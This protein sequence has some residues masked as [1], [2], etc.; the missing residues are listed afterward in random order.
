MKILYLVHQFYPEYYTGT[1]KFVLNLSSM[2]QKLGNQVK[3]ITYSFRENI[4][5][6]NRIGNI[7]YKDFYYKGIPVKAIKHV[8]VPWDIHFSFKDNEMKEFALK[9]IEDEKPDIVHVGHSMRIGEFIW[10]LI[11]L[12]IPYIITL[13]DFFFICYK[14][15]LLKKSGDLCIGPQGG[16][17]YKYCGE[18]TEQ[19]IKNRLY[20]AHKI[21][22]NAEIVASPSNFV[23]KVIENEFKDIN[24]KVIKHGMSYNNIR[25]N[26]RI[27]KKND[28]LTFCYAG[29]L[30][31][32]KGV[33][34]I[35]DAFT[36]IKNDNISL[37]I[38][39]S[40][41]DKDYIYR[42]EN[43]SKS[44]SRIEFCGVYNEE[45]IGEIYSDADV[46]IVPSLWFENYP[47]VLH[48]A[49]ACNVPVI[50]SNVGGMKEKVKDGYNGFTF[51]I[52]NSDD[53]KMKMQTII[54]N[55]LILNELKSKMKTFMIPTVEQEAYAY[56][57]IYKSII[58]KKM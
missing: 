27:Y 32:H 41:I 10:A 44:D 12:K 17:C 58:Y 13:T 1:E 38:Y 20:D 43:A 54:D 34:I 22:A 19:I 25:K 45:Q 53:L 8:Q 3:I 39:G 6:D 51:E 37:K 26:K 11:K 56:E 4:F 52:G 21:L 23:A 31:P 35:I 28:K 42:L 30:T 49:L 7:L 55:S 16:I 50:A 46:S 9:I 36:K 14:Y 15:I 40:G 47:L 18:L 57:R 5:F 24:I 29:S 48:E 2:M 33:H